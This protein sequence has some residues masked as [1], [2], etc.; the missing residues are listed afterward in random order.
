MESQSINQSI[1]QSI[2]QAKNGS[3]NQS[4]NGSNQSIN[5]YTDLQTN[6]SRRHL[7]LI[8]KDGYWN[9]KRSLS[10][11]IVGVSSGVHFKDFFSIKPDI[12]Y[13]Y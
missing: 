12:V 1:N 8:F 4:T 7:D 2:E 9:S 3:I 5:Q 13:E 11:P 6:L 10:P